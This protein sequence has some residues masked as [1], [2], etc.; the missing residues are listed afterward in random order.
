MGC[1]G[2]WENCEN[3]RLWKCGN[4]KTANDGRAGAPNGR[5]RSPI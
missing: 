2:A 5:A 4:M 1:G 3:V